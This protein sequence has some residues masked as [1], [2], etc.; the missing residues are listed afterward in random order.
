[1]PLIDLPLAELE[2][3]GGRNP[4]P[5]DFDDYWLRG[6]R[7]LAAISADVQINPFD[8]PSKV[9]DCFEL[10]FTGTGGARI[11]SKLLIPKGLVGPA[12]ALLQFH[13]YTMNSGDWYEKLGW[14]SQ[15]FVVAAMDCRGQGGKSEDVGGTCGN[16]LNGQIIR[17]LDDHED[18]LLFRH[19]FLDTAR[20]AQVVMALPEVDPTRVACMG[21]SQGGGLSLACAALVPS[22]GKCAPAYPFLSDYLRSWEMDA[23]GS[24]YSELKNYFRSFDPRHERHEEIFTKL[25]YI[26]IQH[27]MPRV[28]AEVLMAVG[29]M[30]QVTLPSTCIAAY[31]KIGSP[32]RLAVYPDFGH[33]PL[34]GF[35]DLAF[36]FLAD[37]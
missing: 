7:D 26:D 28:R 4:R 3:Y 22:I 17:G 31:N 5:A 34:P 25:G 11:Y 30:D 12:P 20:L 33:E 13:G 9:A 21:G 29:L 24:A 16:T 37:L 18:K 23:L 36:R 19:I 14:V 8:L 15:G 2:T 1:M 27:L 6:L 35:G 32:K 10:T